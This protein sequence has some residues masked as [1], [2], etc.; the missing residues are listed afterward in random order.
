MTQSLNDSIFNQCLRLLQIF[1][2]EPLSEPVVDL[3]QQLG[4]LVPFVVARDVR[5]SRWH[6]VPKI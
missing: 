2:L 6:G 1:R 4:G 5:G 3:G